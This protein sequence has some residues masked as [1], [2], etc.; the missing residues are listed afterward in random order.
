M[1]ARAQ[2]VTIA[3][4]V[5]Q[6]TGTQ[7]IAPGALLE[8][9]STPDDTVYCRFA[10]ASKSTPRCDLTVDGGGDATETTIVP[11]Q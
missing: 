3:L 7:T 6:D 5:V 4:G 1:A 9:F 11:A 10:K 2:Q 8:V